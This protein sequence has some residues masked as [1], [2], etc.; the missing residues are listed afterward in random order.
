MIGDAFQYAVIYGTGGKVES[1]GDDLRH[2]L[3]SALIG[4]SNVG[5][6]NK[7]DASDLWTKPGRT[8]G[9]NV[10]DTSKLNINQRVL[11]QLQGVGLM[12]CASST[13]QV[14]HQVRWNVEY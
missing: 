9:F 2:R 5:A 1:V 8:G 10:L 3:T 13:S 7:T 4:V 12:N 6:T 11:V 14:S